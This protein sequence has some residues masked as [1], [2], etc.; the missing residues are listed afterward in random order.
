MYCEI[1][2][3]GQHRKTGTRCI[4]K[5]TRQ[6]KHCQRVKHG[7][8]NRK[9]NWFYFPNLLEICSYSDKLIITRGW[10]GLSNEKWV[11]RRYETPTLN[12]ELSEISEISAR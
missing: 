2:M 4:M 6:S 10:G 9:T 5:N 11:V 7:K 12:D 1:L 3:R 8:Y